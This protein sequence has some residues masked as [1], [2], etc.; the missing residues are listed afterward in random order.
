MRICAITLAMMLAAMPAMAAPVDGNWTGTVAG[1]NGEITMGFLFKADGENLNGSMLGFDGNPVPL[2]GGKIDGNN[3]S[4]SVT[5]SFNGNSFAIAY[6]G[7]VGDDQIKMT[8]DFQG[9]GF[10]FV[11]KKTK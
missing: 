5:L 9:Q 6:K 4:F 1:P 3:I 7:V 10:D 11:L 8:G 2:D